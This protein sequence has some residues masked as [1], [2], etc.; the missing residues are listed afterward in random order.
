MAGQGDFGVEQWS[1][2]SMSFNLRSQSLQLLRKWRV[3]SLDKQRA[4]GY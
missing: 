3:V 4:I 2:M 1:T